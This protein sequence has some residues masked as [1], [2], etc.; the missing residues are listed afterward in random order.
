MFPV[1]I[2]K[3]ECHSSWCAVCTD[4]STKGAKLCTVKSV[5]YVGVC[6][7]CEKSHKTN[8]T[9]KHRGMY[10]GQTYRTLAERAKEHRT[11]YRDLDFKNFMFKHRVNIPLS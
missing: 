1:S 2:F 3:R 9:Q 5:V 10:V 4:S 7:L 11:G 6:Q 8:P